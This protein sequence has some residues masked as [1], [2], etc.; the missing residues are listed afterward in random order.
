MLHPAVLLGRSGIAI[1][2]REDG[3]G[4][5][6]NQILQTAHG[7]ENAISDSN[8]TFLIHTPSAGNHTYYFTHLNGTR[9]N[10]IGVN[11]TIAAFEF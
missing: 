4:V 2:L 1:R 7:L 9:P 6:G 5:N 3:T 11:A 10:D 8:S